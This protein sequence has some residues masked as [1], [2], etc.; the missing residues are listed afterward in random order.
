MTP[1]F[2][3][4]AVSSV[5]YGPRERGMALLAALMALSILTLIGL[6]VTFVTTTE[7]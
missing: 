2:A 6:T 7:T 3:G 5:A 4:K 1:T